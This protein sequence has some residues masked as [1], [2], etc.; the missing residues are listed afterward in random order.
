[1][2]EQC[3]TIDADEL[4]HSSDSLSLR[5]LGRD[6]LRWC[7]RYAV[8][9]WFVLASF[10]CGIGAAVCARYEPNQTAVTTKGVLAVLA[11]VMQAIGWSLGLGSKKQSDK[12]R[13]ANE[14]LRDRLQ[15]V[16]Y[17]EK[18]MDAIFGAWLKYILNELKLG[19]DSRASF[20]LWDDHGKVGSEFLFVAREATNPALRKQGRDRFP[21]DQGVISD[22]WHS[23]DGVA[24][25]FA[26]KNLKTDED[27]LNDMVKNCHLSEADAARLTMISRMIIGHVVRHNQSNVGIL[28]V[29]SMRKVNEKTK[30]TAY[31]KACSDL[32][33]KV[34]PCLGRLFDMYSNAV[35]KQED[36]TEEQ[37]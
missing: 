21:G 20:Y 34:A 5:T 23:D 11:I 2:V 14:K 9:N 33:K 10:L 30:R 16:A 15:R 28:I 8:G 3:E 24:S 29:E 25:Y 13:S 7:T 17:F 32:M 12:L 31:V 1:M 18:N 35:F 26:G 27:V 22:A 4:P 6:A 19:N 36:P 37:Q